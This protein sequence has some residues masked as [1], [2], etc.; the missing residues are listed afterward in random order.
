MHVQP[1]YKS[2]PNVYKLQE[3]EQKVAAGFPNPCEEFLSKPISLDDLLIK[4]HSSTFLVRVSGD[5]M[6]PTIPCGALLVVDKSIH[7]SNNNIVVAV[8]DNEFIV[9][10]FVTHLGTSPILHSHN[11]EYS[12]VIIDEKNQECT[13]IWGVVTSFIKQL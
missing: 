6:A 9:K 7:P 5:S 1:L 12:D 11:S 10:E 4:R 8:V 2:P 3:L 13:E